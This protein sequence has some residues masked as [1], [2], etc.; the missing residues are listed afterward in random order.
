MTNAANELRLTCNKKFAPETTL[1]IS[2]SLSKQTPSFS[3]KS[4]ANLYAPPPVACAW[5]LSYNFL[6]SLENKAQKHVTQQSSVLMSCNNLLFW[7]IDTHNTR[8]Q[9]L[10]R[11]VPITICAYKMSYLQP[12]KNSVF[13]AQ[14]KVI[15]FFSEYD[16][17][18]YYFC[19]SIG[20]TSVRNSEQ[21]FKN[22]LQS[23]INKSIKYT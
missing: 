9:I 3:R 4:S 16:I 7:M 23:N 19:N 18:K 2:S 12:G 11:I 5:Y 13:K 17:P 21:L 14:G 22:N 15:L 20:I 10:T 8:H 6:D 1:S